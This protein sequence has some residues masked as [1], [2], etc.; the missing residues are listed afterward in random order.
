MGR[1]RLNVST[2]T[3]LLDF[4]YDT[5]WNIS[6]GSFLKL[7]YLIRGP[8][9]RIMVNWGLYWVPPILGNHHRVWGT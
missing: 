4:P 2:A 3:F 7:G 5:N 9:L 8:G 6:Y 1:P